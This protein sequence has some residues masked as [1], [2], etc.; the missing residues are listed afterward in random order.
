MVGSGEEKK[1][2]I[3][4]YDFET[5]QDDS[6]KNHASTTVHILILCVIQK[7]CTDCENNEDATIFCENCGTRQ[8]ILDKDPVNELIAH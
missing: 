3:V 2:L 5:R 6:Y 4:F 7:V 8:R 1:I